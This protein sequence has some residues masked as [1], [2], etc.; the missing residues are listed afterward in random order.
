[1]NYRNVLEFF[2]DDLAEEHN[3]AASFFAERYNMELCKEPNYLLMRRLGLNRTFDIWQRDVKTAKKIMT[4]GDWMKKME[5]IFDG[6]DSESRHLQE[7]FD[8][9]FHGKGKAYVASLIRDAI[10]G[11]DLDYPFSFN[12]QTIL[13]LWKLFFIHPLIFF[14]IKYEMNRKPHL[15]QLTYLHSQGFNRHDFDQCHS[16]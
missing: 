14:F 15:D 13:N 6:K 3:R 12:F 1:M 4:D 5:D 16:L 7:S 11:T 8:E 10:H 9:A 2:R